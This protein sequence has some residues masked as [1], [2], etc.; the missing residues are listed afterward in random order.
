M[1]DDA[2]DDRSR[3]W[4]TGPEDTATPG[5]L[6]QVWRVV[7]DTAATLA[8]PVEHADILHRLALAWC[9]R[10]YTTTDPTELRVAIDRTEAEVRIRIHRA[11]R[12]G[13]GL[14]LVYPTSATT[15]NTPVTWMPQVP[16]T[17][18]VLD[19]DD[20]ALPEPSWLAGCVLSLTVASVAGVTALITG[21]IFGWW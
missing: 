3:I 12:T 21:R 17:P 6:D 10:R 1:F 11:N 18:T 13:H 7:Y 9:Q 2:S 8:A 15:V 16:E 5:G 19:L 20:I 4:I 14:R